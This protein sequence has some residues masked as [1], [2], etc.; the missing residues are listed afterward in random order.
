MTC[1]VRQDHAI[2]KFNNRCQIQEYE[3]KRNKQLSMTSTNT[4]IFL[5]LGLNVHLSIKRCKILKQYKKNSLSYRGQGVTTIKQNQI[6][7]LNF[8]R[9]Q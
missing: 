1:S 9:S 8:R 3:E 6:V 4:F 5:Q 7:N 2:H